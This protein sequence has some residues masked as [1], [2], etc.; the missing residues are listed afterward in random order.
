MGIHDGHRERLR[1]LCLHG[2]FD[3]LSDPQKL[4]FLLTYAIP[5]RDVNPIAHAL[6]EH[7]GSFSAVLSAVPEELMKVDGV[8]ESAAVLLSA[9]SSAAR[10][11]KIQRAEEKKLLDSTS[12]VGEFLIPYFENNVEESAYLLFLDAKCR[13]IRCFKLED[14]ELNTVDIPVRQI[15]EKALQQKA[16][17]V[18]LAHNHVSGVCTPSAEDL[19]TTREVAGVLKAV[20]VT[21]VDHVIV[22]GD[23]YYSMQEHGEM[24]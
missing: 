22:A 5:R 6:L 10:Y 21:L 24:P 16:V 14:G 13:L 3:A 4:E 9:V 15:V 20:G 23:G 19:K 12:K 2:G 17:M 7:F 1:K 8:G 11:G 18:V